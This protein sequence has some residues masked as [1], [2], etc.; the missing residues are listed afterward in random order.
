MLKGK[1]ANIKKKRSRTFEDFSEALI[2][3]D[4]YRMQMD[5]L[6]SEL[7]TAHELIAIA[8]KRLVSVDTYFTIDN[9]WL[10]TFVETGALNEMTPEL[11]KHLIDRIDVYADKRIQI[12]FSY[13]NW[14]EPLLDCFEEIKILEAEQQSD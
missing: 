9:K 5:K 4:V 10:R 13:S 11:I 6:A 8:E 7:D 12:T 3:E 1:V 14:M 2:D